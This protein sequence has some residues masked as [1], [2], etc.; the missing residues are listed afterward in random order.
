MPLSEVAS[1]VGKTDEWPDQ[2][3]LEG[4]REHYPE[5]KLSSIVQVIEYRVP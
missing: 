1:F 2:I 4:M 5:I 3:M